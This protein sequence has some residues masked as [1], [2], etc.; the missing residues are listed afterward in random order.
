[1]FGNSCNCS[2]S[3]PPP[4]R[5]YYYPTSY[6]RRT[7]RVSGCEGCPTME[8]PTTLTLTITKND[9]DCQCVAAQSVA[10]EY[11]DVWTQPKGG[12]GVCTL[13]RCY[14]SVVPIVDCSVTTPFPSPVTF[15]VYWTPNQ[16]NSGE[17]DVSPRGCFTLRAIKFDPAPN[18]CSV[19]HFIGTRGT[20]TCSPI[21]IPYSVTLIGRYLGSP[22]PDSL[23]N[24]TPTH[25]F[26]ITE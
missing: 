9:A 23:C 18:P 25:Y 1:M 17:D 21:N 19:S 8:L 14:R 5:R 24:V 26:T 16:V 3:S 15:Y 13:V 2:C 4:A 20:V 6:Y 10:M 12:G 22:P 11:R 7:V